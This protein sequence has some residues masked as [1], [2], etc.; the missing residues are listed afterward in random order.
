M[1]IPSCGQ[2]LA[3]ADFFDRIIKLNEE[4]YQRSDKKNDKIGENA[5]GGG[6]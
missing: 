3:W 6:G 5:D 4:D 2:F 1:H